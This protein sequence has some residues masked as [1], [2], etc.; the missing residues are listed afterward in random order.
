MLPPLP[1]VLKHKEADF[2]IKFRAWIKEN[3][4]TTATFELK[5][6]QTDSISFSCLDICQIIYNLA[7]KKLVRVQGTIGEPDYIYLDRIPAYIVIKYKSGFCIIKIENFINE[8]QKGERKSLTFK[9]AKQ[10]SI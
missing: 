8:K 6:S 10:I 5:Q 2:G 4:N 1:R 3:W 7:D 9:R